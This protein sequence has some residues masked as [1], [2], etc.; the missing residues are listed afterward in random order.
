MNRS[1][2]NRSD[3][4][5]R[6][7]E[8][9]R[10]RRA[11]IIK[12]LERANRNKYRR[13]AELNG[14]VLNRNSP[15][16]ELCEKVRG[17]KHGGVAM[18]LRLAEHTGLVHEI[19][20]RVHVL[21]RHCPYQ[22][23]D[24]VLNF[25]IN[26]LC[27][28]TCLEDIEL[29]RN[30]EVFLD[31][32]GVDAIPDPTTAGDFCRRF[33]EPTIRRLMDATNAARLNVWKQQPD[34]FFDE[35]IVDFD[36]VIVGTTGECKDGMDISYKGDWGYH[37]LL[38]SLAN[39]KEP[40]SIVNRSGN[41]PSEEDAWKEADAVVPAL[42]RAG[43]RSI[44]FRGDS[45]FS[46]TEHL[47]RWNAGGVQFQFGYP[48]N[49]AV[50][51][52]AEDLP[53]NA[54]TE[55]KRPARY[56]VK[57]Q[58]RVRPENIK[59]KIV[60]QRAFLNLRLQSEQVAEFNYQPTACTK[61]YR[62]VVVR[63]NISREKGEEVLFDEIRYFFYITNDRLTAVEDIVFGCNDRGD[64]ENLIAQLAGGVR[65]LTAPVDNLVSNWAYMVMTSLAWSLKAWAALLQ[66]VS[67]RWKEQHQ[68]EQQTIMRME[69]KQ[70]I[71]HFVQVPCQI[72]RQGRRTIHRILNWNKWHAHFFR[73]SEVL[74]L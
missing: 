71:E 36:G 5:K 43:F 53:E 69:F 14:P 20:R 46:Q 7:E 31:S 3:Q 58:P 8:R 10:R 25:A 59:A 39:T 23:S 26:A 21:K 51:S 28:G 41:R 72:I 50:K 24:H 70:F 67:P 18:I 34:E 73:L 44:R 65:G 38:T 30:D 16:Y 54:W 22:E 6:R 55:L 19:D 57:T 63:K 62:M 37:P 74:Q 56:A 12:R 42:R 52:R 9:I 11:K 66:P 27:G 17:T 48:D 33:D 40:L 47:D 4:H 35:A 2:T 61:S 60:R 45:K 29:R 49:S 68:A 64:Q 15:K 32:L 13:A 1:I